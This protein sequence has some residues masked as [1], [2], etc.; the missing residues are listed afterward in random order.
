MKTLLYVSLLVIALRSVSA[1]HADLAIVSADSSGSVSFAPTAIVLPV[2]NAVLACVV[3]ATG[4]VIIWHF[5]RWLFAELK[6]DCD[7]L[8]VERQPI[9]FEEWER[10]RHIEYWRDNT[11]WV[12]DDGS[13][14]VDNPYYGPGF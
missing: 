2:V 3:A 13:F 6:R 9:S 7:S 14:L 5:S 11:G 10:L 4:L 1:V 8:E 12:K